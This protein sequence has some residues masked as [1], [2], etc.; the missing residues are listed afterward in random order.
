MIRDVIVTCLLVT[1]TWKK[2]RKS[3]STPSGRHSHAVAVSQDGVM[4][5]YGGISEGKVMQDLYSY[6]IGTVTLTSNAY[7]R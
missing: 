3:R 6:H 4:F 2:L 5:V 1:E 7:Y